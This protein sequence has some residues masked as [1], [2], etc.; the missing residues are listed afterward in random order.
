MLSYFRW[1]QVH[2]EHVTCAQ[3]SESIST[4]NNK[5]TVIVTVRPYTAAVGPGI[6]LVHDNGQP[7]VDSVCSSWMMHSGHWPAIRL[8]WPKS[9][10]APLCISM[11]HH[12]VPQQ[13][14][15]MFNDPS[16]TIRRLIRSMPRGC[17]ECIKVHYELKL[18]VFTLIF[19]DL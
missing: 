11:Q 16:H 15:Q 13:S 14:V 7:R 3:T 18:K 6:L 10:W 9:K 2:D 19:S 12:K 4:L 1:E 8:P 5:M 17:Q